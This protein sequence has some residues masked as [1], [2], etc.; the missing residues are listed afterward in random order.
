M[1]NFNKEKKAEALVTL[2]A[3]MLQPDEQ[4]QQLILQAKN[5]NGWFTERE[6]NNAVKAVASSLNAEDL[7]YWLNDYEFRSSAKKIGLVLAGNIPMVGFHDI[8]CVLL[9]GHHA[10]IKLSSQDDMLIPY[11]LNK[12]IEIEPEFKSQISFVNRLENFDAVIATGSNNSSR[13]FE[14]YFSKVPHIIR[15]NRNSIAVLSGKESEIELK[16]LGKDI[17]DYYGLGC[18]NVSKVLVP[19]DYNFI[20]FFEAIEEYNTIINHHKYQNNYDYNKS[21]YLVNKVEHLDNGFLLLTRNEQLSSPLSVLYFEEYEDLKTAETYITERSEQIQVVITHL[22]LNIQNAKASF[23][24]SQ[25]PK[26]WDYADGI[27]TMKFLA[28]LN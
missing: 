6:V 23:G 14:Y 8:I 10:L 5:K 15:K 22:N 7:T 11:I 3:Y 25:Q 1:S 4:L 13:Y 27:D 16:A 2:G 21:I 26:L 24:E 20:P 17:L 19:K 18:R 12:L 9:A 28:T